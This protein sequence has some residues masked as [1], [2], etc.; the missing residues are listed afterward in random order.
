LFVGPAHVKST[1]PLSVVVESSGTHSPGSDESLPLTHVKPGS[2]VLLSG[3]VQAAHDPGS[4]VDGAPLSIVGALSEAHLP[5]AFGSLPITQLRPALHFWVTLQVPPTSLTVARGAAAGAAGLLAEADGDAGPP[6]L[7]LKSAPAP[8]VRPP[9]PPQATIAG[10]IVKQR[11]KS[12]V[13]SM[14]MGP[15]S[16]F[17]PGDS[18]NAHVRPTRLATGGTIFP[19]R[20]SVKS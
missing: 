3:P 11:A 1:D 9:D 7:E 17:V 15:S 12:F 6:D 20:S 10:A 19:V 5:D 4:I 2:H 16:G 8:S 13:R 14:S 18:P